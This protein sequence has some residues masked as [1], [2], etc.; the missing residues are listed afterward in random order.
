MFLGKKKQFLIH[1]KR[2]SVVPYLAKYR[3]PENYKKKFEAIQ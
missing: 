1:K 2:C 3:P